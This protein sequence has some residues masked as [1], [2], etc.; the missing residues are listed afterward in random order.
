MEKTVRVLKPSD[1]RKSL[2]FGIQAIDAMDNL[3]I[4]ELQKAK[5]AGYLNPDGTF[6]GGWGG[7]VRHMKSGGK[8]QES[9]E[10]I[11]GYIKARKG[12]A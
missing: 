12:G 9:A 6:K 3:A 2:R 7:C 8:S 4:E 10:K 1:L 5:K 11:C